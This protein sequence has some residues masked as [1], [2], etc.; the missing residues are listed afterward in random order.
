MNETGKIK[1]I[2]LSALDIWSMGNGNGAPSFYNTLKL[3]LDKGHEVTLIKP[4]GS[5]HYNDTIPGLKI[6]T[7]D[8]DFY[9]SLCAVPKVSF[10]GRI[11]SAKHIYKEMY[12]LGKAEIESSD[13]QCLLYAYEVHAVKAAKRLADEYGFPVISRFQGT[14]LYCIKDSRLNRLKHYPRFGAISET[15]DMVIM[16]DDG[17]FGDQVLDRLGNKTDTVRFWRNGVSFSVPSGD[18]Y[19]DSLKKELSIDESDFVLLTL[20]RLAE[21]KRV[22]RAITAMKELLPTYPQ[23]KLIIAGQGA[24]KAKLEKMATDFGLSDRI[25][26]AG[27]VNQA[28]T[29]KYYSIA[30]VFMSLY[31]LSNL[32]NPLFEALHFGKPVVTLDVGNTGSVIKNGC[33]G[34]LVPPDDVEALRAAVSALIDSKEL[35]LEMSANAAR[36]ADENFWT[37]PE[38]MEAE[39]ADVMDVVDRF[40]KTREECTSG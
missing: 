38:R 36:Y 17:S 7:F 5:R 26:F 21:W 15:A 24:E 14:I 25:V 29:W 27:S 1:V 2:F 34:M 30:D 13:C 19:V 18:T 33:N 39:Y 3:Y 23:L 6:V 10:F 4:T 11:L 28:D 20:C 9:D 32:G 16:T 31:D 37:W 12:R 35:R 22:D 8:N 40:Y